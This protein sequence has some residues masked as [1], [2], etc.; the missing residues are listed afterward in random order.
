MPFVQ[1]EGF[2]CEK[3]GHVEQIVSK[4]AIVQQE[5][6]SSH[7]FRRGRW[8]RRERK[9]LYLLRRAGKTALE[10]AKELNRS[11]ASVQWQ[12]KQLMSESKKGK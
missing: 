10:V 3:C 12:M 4:T 6:T 11:P 5:P 1:V 9:K 7:R 2:E 8:G